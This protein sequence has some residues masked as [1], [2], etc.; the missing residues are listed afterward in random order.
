MASRHLKEAQGSVGNPKKD[1]RGSKPPEIIYGYL[2]VVSNISESKPY[3]FEEAVD[4]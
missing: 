3:N 1:V 4:M 2:A